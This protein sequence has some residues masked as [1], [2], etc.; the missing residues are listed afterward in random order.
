MYCDGLIVGPR[1]HRGNTL[2]DILVL[3]RKSRLFQIIGNA[4]KID[5]PIADN[6]ESILRAQMLRARV[7]IPEENVKIVIREI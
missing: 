5:D 4:M 7:Y 2:Q 6:D 1:F 3:V